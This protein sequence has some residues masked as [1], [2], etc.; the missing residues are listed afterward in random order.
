VFRFWHPR[1][2]RVY[3]S[4]APHRCSTPRQTTC[5][6]GFRAA[7]PW[8]DRSC[9]LQGQHRIRAYNSSNSSLKSYFANTSSGVQLTRCIDRHK[10]GRPGAYPAWCGAA[11]AG[12]TMQCQGCCKQQAS[13]EARKHTPSSPEGRVSTPSWRGDSPGYSQRTAARD[14]S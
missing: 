10:A 2:L 5:K 13:V 7:D 1:D 4:L 3:P 9:G 12:P 8:P 6:N 11:C 14:R